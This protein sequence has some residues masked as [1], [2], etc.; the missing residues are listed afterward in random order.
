MANQYTKNPPI[1]ERFWSK[2]E[3]LPD[4]PGCWLWTGGRTPNGYGKFAVKPRVAIGAHRFAYE[5]TIGPV[6][7]GLFV[8]HHCDTRPCV[9]P[10]HLFLGT[11]SE[12]ILDASRKGRAACGDRS[13]PRLYPERLTRGEQCHSARLTAEQ[14]RAIVERSRAGEQR[15]ALGREYGVSSNSISKIA[16]GKSWRHVTA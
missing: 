11:N 12:N 16:L 13:G 14:V 3:R 6:P 2:V 7:D 10:D 8:C 1:E 5:L 15:S 4:L 9:R